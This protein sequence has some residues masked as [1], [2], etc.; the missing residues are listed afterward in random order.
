MKNA[1]YYILMLTVISLCG[2]AS[3][4]GKQ[5]TIVNNHIYSLMNSKEYYIINKYHPT[6]GFNMHNPPLET[7]TVDKLKELDNVET[8]YPYIQIFMNHVYYNTEGELIRDFINEYKIIVNGEEKVFTR[9]N[10]M[11]QFYT[12]PYYPEAHFELI[13]SSQVDIENGVYLSASTAAKLGIEE[14]KEGMTIEYTLP[15]PVDVVDGESLVVENENGE[16]IEITGLKDEYCVLKSIKLP[17]AG[18]LDNYYVSFYG[19]KNIYIP[20]EVLMTLIDENKNSFDYN[21]YIFYAN[22]EL[23]L[24]SFDNRIKTID[25]HLEIFSMTQ[26]LK[27]WDYETMNTENMIMLGFYILICVTVL[28]SFVYS[29]YLRKVNRGTSQV[30]QMFGYSQSSRKKY[31]FSNLIFTLIILLIGSTL[32]SNLLYFFLFHA[33]LIVQYT[34]SYIYYR[35]MMSVVLSLSILIP[36][37]TYIPSFIR[38]EN[39]K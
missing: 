1:L 26:F 23:D 2:I 11:P 20:Y 3:V 7:E 38:N 19:N 37:I 5:G 34:K 21:T 27:D 4:F 39:K 36:F 17:I 6:G 18:I 32:L 33:Q 25:P 22:N 14:V 13:C 30:L 15:I 12:F 8:I 16:P 29:F 35:M 24:E 31:L 9:K 10:Q 28:L